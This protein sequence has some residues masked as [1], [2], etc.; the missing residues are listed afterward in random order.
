MAAAATPGA[1][2]QNDYVELYNRG[3]SAGRHH[4]AGRC[5]TP[6]AT[7][8]GWDFSKQPLGGTIAP[9]QYYLIALASGGADGASLPAAQINGQIN[10]SGTSGKLALVNSFDGA[11]RQLPDQRST[12]DG[13]RRL[14]R[15]RLP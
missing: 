12:P 15:R 4:A 14:R 9:G 7:G 5:S 3:A 6:S 2:Y 1:T 8:S 10:I 13:L 11:D